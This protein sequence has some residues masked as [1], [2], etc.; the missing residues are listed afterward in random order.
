MLNKNG[1]YLIYGRST[2]FA[3]NYA[4]AFEIT[5]DGVTVFKKIFLVNT[6][7]TGCRQTP[8]GG[9]LFLGNLF[10]GPISTRFFICKMSVT[11]NVDWVKYHAPPGLGTSIP[12]FYSYFTHDIIESGDGNYLCFVGSVN[13]ENSN[14]SRVYKVDPNGE[15]LDSIAISFGTKNIFVGGNEHKNEFSGYP[16]TNG[17]CAAGKKDGTFLAF[18]NNAAISEN[19]SNT[20]ALKGSQAFRLNFDNNL[21]VKYTRNLQ[22]SYPDY[23]TSVCTTSDGRIAAFGYISSFG[24]YNKPVILI[25]E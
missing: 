6:I 21:T 20:S 13:P 11:G 16:R 12:D 17:Y 2:A 10:D 14:V 3:P 1:N 23:F 19:I 24:G 25:T 8:D 9:Y 22:T 18:L 4:L 15:L 7:F 5:H